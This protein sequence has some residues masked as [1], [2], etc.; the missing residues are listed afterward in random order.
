M[1]EEEKNIMYISIVIMIILM[2]KLFLL[3][4]G[5]KLTHITNRIIINKNKK[6][7]K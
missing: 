6:S 4:K 3:K 2:K 5:I 7:N 1:Q